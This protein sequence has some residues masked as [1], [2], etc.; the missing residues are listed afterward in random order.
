MQV[1]VLMLDPTTMHLIGHLRQR[2]MKEELQG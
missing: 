1:S 2:K